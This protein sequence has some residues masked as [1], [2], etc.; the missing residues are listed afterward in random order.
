MEEKRSVSDG[1]EDLVLWIQGKAA[2]HVFFMT[3]NGALERV[4]LMS[5]SYVR[6]HNCL[7]R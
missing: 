2:L 1:N 4:Q 5:D 7:T 3:A 6:Y